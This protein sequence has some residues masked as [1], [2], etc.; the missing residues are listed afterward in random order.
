MLQGEQIHFIWTDL[1]LSMSESLSNCYLRYLEFLQLQ[2]LQV[3]LETIAFFS[4]Q[5]QS[6]RG[7]IGGGLVTFTRQHPPRP[8]EGQ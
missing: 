5:V 1:A 3:G 8:G 6:D 7:A 4:T 2:L